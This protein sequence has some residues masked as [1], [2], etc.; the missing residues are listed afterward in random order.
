MALTPSASTSYLP[1]EIS[2]MPSPFLQHGTDAQGHQL[3]STT[4]ARSPVFMN[5]PS[6]AHH[7]RHTSSLSS[8]PSLYAQD[9]EGVYPDHHTNQL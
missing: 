3:G 1:L 2:R 6:F 5:L 4:P 9:E 8:V 7:H